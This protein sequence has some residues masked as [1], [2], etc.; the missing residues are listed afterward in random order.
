MRINVGCGITPTK[1]WKNFD[2]TLSLRLSRLGPFAELYYKLR[3]RQGSLRYIRFCREN[4]IEYADATKK[5]PVAD[6]SADVLYSSHVFEHLDSFETVAFLKEV[7]RVLCPGGILRLVV[8]D[9]RKLVEQYLKTG[10]ADKFAAATYLCQPKP[11]TMIQKLKLLLPTGMQHYHRW[12]YDGESLS[13]LLAKE[14]FQNVTVLPPG[15]TKIK[16]PGE[17]DLR[18]R[19]EESIYVEA[20]K[21]LA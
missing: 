7:K 1:S 16:D 11:R 2:N 14:G 3:S 12:L 6:G 18:E 20:E 9:L 21:L 19:E 13:R 15:E 10:D 4:H 8:P 5:L 17:L